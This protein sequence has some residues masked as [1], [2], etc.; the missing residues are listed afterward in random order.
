[1]FKE[2]GYY[3]KIEEVMSSAIKNLQSIID[4]DVVVGRPIIENQTMTIIPLTKVIFGYIA[5]G[6]EYYSEL[7]E[8]KKDTEYPFSG[9]SGGGLNLQPIGFLVVKNNCVEIIKIEEKSALEKLIEVVPEITSFIAKN[10]S[11]DKKYD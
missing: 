10:F 9:G 6:G 3:N 2:K 5:S 7:K 4:V 1:M 8:L 11:K